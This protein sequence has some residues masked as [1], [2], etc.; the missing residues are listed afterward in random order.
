MAKRITAFKCERTGRIFEKEKD[1]RDSENKFT[2]ARLNQLQRRIASGKYWVPKVGDLVYVR[3]HFSIDHGE[4]DELGGLARVTRVHPSMSGGD[5]KC[6]FIDVAQH[7]VGC[8]WTQFLWPEQK[9]LME[10]FGESVARPD[11]DYG[12]EQPKYRIGYD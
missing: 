7:A 10:E 4:D 12:E 5:P 11:P 3:S 2:K 6:M 9:Y 8:N 1:A